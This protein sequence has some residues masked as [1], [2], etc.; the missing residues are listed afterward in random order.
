MT[1]E[2]TVQVPNTL[3]LHVRPATMLAQAAARFQAD[4]HVIRDGEVADAKSSMSLLTLAAVKD[5]V[6]NIR[7]T[8][9]DAEEAVR[10]IGDIIA[11]GFG[12]E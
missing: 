10:V 1:A 4:I 9:P 11:A 12:E 6:L 3:G 8:G 2:R 7:A 5:T